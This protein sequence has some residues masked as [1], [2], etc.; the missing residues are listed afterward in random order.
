MTCPGCGGRC[1]DIDYFSGYIEDE[2][3]GTYIVGQGICQTCGFEV[4][5]IDWMDETGEAQHL[6]WMTGYETPKEIP[7]AIWDILDESRNQARRKE[8]EKD[9]H[10]DM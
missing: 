3:Y 1:E 2:E 6:M 10:V 5:N 8:E 7:K 4:V 9:V